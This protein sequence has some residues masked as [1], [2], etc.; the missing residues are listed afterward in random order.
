MFDASLGLAKQLRMESV[1]EGVE[2]RADWNFVRERGC[3]VAQGYFIGRPMAAQA[4]PA[5]QAEW[6]T[7]RAGLLQP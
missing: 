3:D 4:F 1:A 5:W 6:E 7:R 2:D